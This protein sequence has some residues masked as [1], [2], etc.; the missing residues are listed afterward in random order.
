[1]ASLWRFV[2]AR[3]QEI[4]NTAGTA[5]VF[6]MAMYNLKQQRELE[7]RLG[8]FQQEMEELARLRGLLDADWQRRAELRIKRDQSSLRREIVERVNGSQQLSEGT[9]SAASP[10]QPPRI[11]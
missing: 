9:N 4:V 10:Q 1:M 5:L 7:A 3:R 2:A 8:G 6:S 11:F